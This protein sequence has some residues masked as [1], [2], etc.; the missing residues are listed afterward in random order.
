MICANIQLLILDMDRRVRHAI[1]SGQTSNSS[2]TRH[3][4]TQSAQTSGE[5]EE[6]TVEATSTMLDSRIPLQRNPY[7]GFVISLLIITFT[8]FINS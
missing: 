7:T 6:E 3:T 4:Q 8:L 5:R 2:H 1:G